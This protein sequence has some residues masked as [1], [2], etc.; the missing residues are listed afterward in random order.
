M[1]SKQ[2]SL[3]PNFDTFGKISFVCFFVSVPLAL[4]V[5]ELWR[6]ILGPAVQSTMGMQ[7]EAA[8]FLATM[9]L[10]A[11]FTA[12]A[13]L[14]ICLLKTAYARIGLRLLRVASLSYVVGSILLCLMGWGVVTSSAALS[15]AGVLLGF[16]SA[17]LAM[18][19]IRRL[20]VKRFR[21]AFI[22]VLA[23]LAAIALLVLTLSLVDARVVA[24]LLALAAC[25]SVLGALRLFKKAGVTEVAGAQAGA[26]WW[27][28]FGRLDVS[29]V[30]GASDFAR[31]L[32]RALLF[33]VLP[34]AMLLLFLFVRTMPA[35]FAMLI[36]PTALACAIAAVALLP[37]ARFKTDQALMNF[38]LRFFLPI[39][40]F[41]V[42]AAVAFVDASLQHAVVLVGV[43][44]FCVA[45]AAI[46][47]A[48]LLTMAGRM[49]SLALPAA[50]IMIIAA[51]LIC[52]L[53]YSQ[54]EAGS[55][56]VFQYPSLL[57]LFTASAVAFMIVPSS[58]L[59]RV[60]LEGIDDAESR[61]SDTTDDYLRRCDDL[62]Q[63]FHLTPRET[64]ILA[65][66]GRGHSSVYVADE[67]VVAESTVR[68]HRKNIYRKLGISSR[69]ELFDLLDQNSR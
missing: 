17:I 54:I 51:C 63:R 15:L 24:T 2:K 52:L 38:S 65:Y 34:L 19:W 4:P 6:S 57:A 68:S 14:F 30:E 67:L 39:V 59:W 10:A 60:V 55:L 8:P 16:G 29:L 28:V 36:S 7:E 46:M 43:L 53:S 56:A 50:G 47:A 5:L 22:V 31:P 35:D 26:N 21:Q 45:Y 48:M 20:Q 13:F 33:V 58:H 66:V 62:A 41:A 69:E 44:T 9:S 18:F 32:A 37:L 49:R 1:A 42:F 23:L 12:L 25:L 3:L 40:A 61:V 64:E 11:M 27:D